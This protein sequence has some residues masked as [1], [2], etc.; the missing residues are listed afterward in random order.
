[1][2]PASE[3]EGFGGGFDGSLDC[4]FASLD[5]FE[6]VALLAMAITVEAMEGLSPLPKSEPL[7]TWRAAEASAPGFEVALSV[8][9]ISFSCT[10][11][12]CGLHFAYKNEQEI[13][14]SLTQLPFEAGAV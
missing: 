7:D 12:V 6:A 10:S 2:S 9:P 4:S 5:S 11:S 13:A 8:L 1:M 3:V 14:C